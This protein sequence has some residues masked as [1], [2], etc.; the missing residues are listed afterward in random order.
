LVMTAVCGVGAIIWLLILWEWKV[1]V[2]G[3]IVMVIIMKFFGAPLK[4]SLLRNKAEKM[5]GGR[6]RSV[7]LFLGSSSMYASSALIGPLVLVELVRG[8]NLWPAILFSYS[9][10]PGAL[11][12]ETATSDT[13]IGVFTPIVGQIVFLIAV[14]L[15]WYDIFPL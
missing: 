1:L 12:A 11:T 3:V 7:F 6:G 9:V 4:N 13:N 8:D 2:V 5:A 14:S 15:F 10:F